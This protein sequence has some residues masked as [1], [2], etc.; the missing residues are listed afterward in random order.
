MHNAEGKIYNM[1]L[2]TPFNMIISG[3]SGSGKT[4][5]LVKHLKYKDI[6]LDSTTAQVIFFYNE[7]Q[8]SYEVLKQ[9]KL[10]DKFYRGIP[11][12]DELMDL[13]LDPGYK[14]YDKKQHKM[15][16]FDDLVS[17]IQDDLLAKLFT[18]YGHHKNVSIILVTQALFNPR[19]NKFNILQENVH[20]L[21]LSK[22]PRD[23][24]KVIYLAKQISPY[25]IHWVVQAFQDATQKAYSYLFFSFKQDCP[26]KLRVRTNIFPDE[27]P[28]KVYTR[29][30]LSKTI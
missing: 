1:I 11:S 14:S 19:V 4:T 22:S 13:L 28:M 30:N 15:L 3:S 29:A 17:E 23:S 21:L 7:W 10:V 25:N 5:K 24:S 26:E 2:Q 18:I 9:L 12:H 27:I 16:I 20:Y 8:D 6:M